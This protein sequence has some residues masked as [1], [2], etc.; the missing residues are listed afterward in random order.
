MKLYEVAEAM[1][2]I[3]G[4]RTPADGNFFTTRQLVTQVRTAGFTLGIV[5]DNPRPGSRPR[6]SGCSRPRR[7]R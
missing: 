5:R 4:P 6:R 1:R 7:G 3:K 2:A